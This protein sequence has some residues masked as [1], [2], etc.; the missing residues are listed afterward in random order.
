MPYV[1][2]PQSG[3]RGVPPMQE[4]ATEMSARHRKAAFAPAIATLSARS[5]ALATIQTYYKSFLLCTISPNVTEP[6]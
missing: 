2:L 3:I 5:D 4:T 6:S 1:V